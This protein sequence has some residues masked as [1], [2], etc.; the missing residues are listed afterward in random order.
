MGIHGNIIFRH[1]LKEIDQLRNIREYFNPGLHHG[2]D[3]LKVN[4]SCNGFLDIGLRHIIELV[5]VHSL[6]IL[7]VHPPKLLYIK[8]CRRLAHMTV[9]KSFYQFLQ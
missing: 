8:D 5:K 7:S 2:S 1:L 4:V 3:L 9:V 6:H